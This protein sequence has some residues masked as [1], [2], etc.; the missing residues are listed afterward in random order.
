VDSTC[1]RANTT[2]PRITVGKAYYK[3]TEVC[4]TM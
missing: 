1:K 2:T 3:L 4:Q